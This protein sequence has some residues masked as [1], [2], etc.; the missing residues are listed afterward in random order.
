MSAKDSSGAQLALIGIQSEKEEGGMELEQMC[1]S[2]HMLSAAVRYSPFVD[3][4]TFNL[5]QT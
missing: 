1:A 3:T 4:L 5:R 2:L